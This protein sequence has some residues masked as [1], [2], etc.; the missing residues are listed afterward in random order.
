MNL[1]AAASRHLRHPADVEDVVQEAFVRSYRQL[2]DL[3]VENPKAY[4]FKAA[5]NLALK[6]NDLAV[7]RLSAALDELDLRDELD[8]EDPWL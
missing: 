4:L 5:R 8:L 3:E 1:D 7:N 2:M 6:Q